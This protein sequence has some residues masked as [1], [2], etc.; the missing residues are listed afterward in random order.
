MLEELVEIKELK[1]IYTLSSGIFNSQKRIF[2]A[3]NNVDLQ[4]L[5][6]ETLGLVGESGW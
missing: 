5:K 3:V 1:K 2:P 4:I 6:G